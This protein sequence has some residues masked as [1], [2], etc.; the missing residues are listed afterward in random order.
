[1]SKFRTRK[2]QICRDAIRSWK[3]WLQL[4]AR[5]GMLPISLLTNG[6]Q[7]GSRWQVTKQTL[8]NSTYSTPKDYERLGL[9]RTTAY[10]P[11]QSYII[12]IDYLMNWS[13]YKP[14]QLNQAIRQTAYRTVYTEIL[15][16][17]C[18]YVTHCRTLTN[19][20]MRYGLITQQQ[21]HVI[22]ECWLPL[23]CWY[24]Q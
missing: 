14:V 20:T 17:H 16:C 8:S 19:T 24:K 22:A 21:R 23:T 13:L 6:V 9:L 5:C 2:Q 18:H 4:S 12:Y 1:M 10:L 7:L 3:S 15:H 11:I